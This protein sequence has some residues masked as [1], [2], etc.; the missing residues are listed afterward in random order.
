ATS[1][2]NP[3]TKSSACSRRSTASTARPSSW[4]HTTRTPPRVRRTPSISTKA[5]SRPSRPHEIPRLH[6]EQSEA[7]ETAHHVDAALY[8]RGVR[9]VRVVERA[10]TCARRRREY[11]G[12]ESA[13]RAS[14]GVVHQFAAPFL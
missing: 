5:S 3:A 13:A 2:A 14:S 1:T 11:G 6:L 7:Q 4:S 10:Q 12:R 8:S 9:V